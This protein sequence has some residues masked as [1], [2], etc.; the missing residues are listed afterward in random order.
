MAGQGLGVYGLA[1]LAD[2]NPN[3]IR[4]SFA[5]GL[6]GHG[7]MPGRPGDNFGVDYFHYQFSND[8]QSSP[9]PLLGLGN[10]QGVEV[11][12]N[13]ALTPWLTLGSDLQYLEPAQERKGPSLV[14]GL[15]LHV[16]Y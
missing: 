12:Y 7:M 1:A 4:G 6:A 2:G 11:F 10:E 16:V 13:L 9:R 8:L 5:G 14:G 15:R 3:A